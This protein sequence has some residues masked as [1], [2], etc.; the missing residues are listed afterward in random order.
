MTEARDA[1]MVGRTSDGRLVQRPISPH[2]QIY[3][4]PISM[5]GSILHRATGIALSVGTLLLVWFLVAAASSDRAYANVSGFIHSFIGV[6][7][8]LGWIAALWYHF[9]AGIRHLAWD[10]GY[11]FSKPDTDRNTYIILGATGVFT[12]VTWIVLFTRL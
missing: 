10:V 6:I 3:K 11:G 4:W 8:L 2:L 9:F 7:L 12:L 5:A 1:L